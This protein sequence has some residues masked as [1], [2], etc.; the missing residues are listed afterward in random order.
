M[1][2]WTMPTAERKGMKCIGMKYIIPPMPCVHRLTCAQCRH[3]MVIMDHLSLYD[4]AAFIPLC[5]PGEDHWF[6][7]LGYT[8]LKAYCEGRIFANFNQVCL[9]CRSVV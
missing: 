7:K 8:P 2:A 5:H 4:G 1:G 3:E 6:E 9:E